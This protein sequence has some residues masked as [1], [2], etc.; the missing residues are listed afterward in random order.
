MPVGER[1]QLVHQPFRVDPAQRMPPDVELTGV[2]AQ[3]DAIAEE[4]VRLDAA[5]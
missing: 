3:H 5:P 4:L 1:I 2:I